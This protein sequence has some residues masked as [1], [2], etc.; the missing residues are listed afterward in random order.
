M[1]TS[2]AKSVVA[3]FDR[4]IQNLGRAA[5]KSH[6]GAAWQ[7]LLFARKIAPRKTGAL[8]AG[9]TVKRNPKSTVLVSSV[10]KSF[11][12]NKWVNMNIAT[13]TLRGKK[14]SYPS[15]R[16]TGMP[17]FFDLTVELMRQKFPRLAK[18]EVDQA[19]RASFR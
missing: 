13:V 15:T 12:Y 10:L 18:V 3:Q 8:R 7:G 19:L 2:N 16:H 5:V 4:A 17:R 6:R 1:I 14:R 9:I 11:P